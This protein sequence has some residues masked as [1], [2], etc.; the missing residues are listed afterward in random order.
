MKIACGNMRWARVGSGLLVLALAMTLQNPAAAGLSFEEPMNPFAPRKTPEKSPGQP[1]SPSPSGEL[2]ASDKVSI[3]VIPSATDP[4]PGQTHHLGVRFNIAPQ[5][6]I[7]YPGQNATGVPPKITLKVTSAQSPAAKFTIGEPI[8]PAPKRYGEDVELLD[9]VYEGSPIV[10]YPIFVPDGVKG[11]LK[12]E[13]AAEYTVCNDICL[14]GKAAGTLE[15][16]GMSSADWTARDQE[17]VTKAIANQPSK[18]WELSLKVQ[19]FPNRTLAISSLDDRLSATRRITFFPHEDGLELADGLKNGTTT[20]GKLMLRFLPKG[21]PNVKGIVTIVTA[22]G[23]KHVL[24][25]IPQSKDMEAFPGKAPESPT[26]PIPVPNMPVPIPPE[27][28]PIK[29]R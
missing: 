19:W 23:V 16:G 7:Y 9:Y 4:T 27:G 12:V 14:T 24:L 5:W 26:R 21:G 3:A 1:S 17:Q 25:D 2:K 6:H 11:P 22:E 29:K 28:D 10:L 15:W 13:W 20:F 18:D 8:Y